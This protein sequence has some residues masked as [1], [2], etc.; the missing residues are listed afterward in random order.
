MV[1]YRELGWRFGWSN[2]GVFVYMFVCG[3][4]QKGGGC[5]WMRELGLFTA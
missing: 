3:H 1:D 5:F 2:G 4:S